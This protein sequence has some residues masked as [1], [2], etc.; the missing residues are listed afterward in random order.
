V[1]PYSITVGLFL[2]CIIYNLR[3]KKWL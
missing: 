1:F 3:E 2:A